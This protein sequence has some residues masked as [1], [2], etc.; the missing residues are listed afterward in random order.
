MLAS[1]GAVINL[2][3]AGRL[4]DSLYPCTVTKYAGEPVQH[5]S[6]VQYSLAKTALITL[7][8]AGAAHGDIRRPK[9]LFDKDRRSCCIPDLASCTLSALSEQKSADSRQ[10]QMLPH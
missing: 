9:L 2:K 6:A 8:Q 5:L 4:Q 7:H 3:M 10:C 1:L